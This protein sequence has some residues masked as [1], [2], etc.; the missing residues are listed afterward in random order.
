MMGTIAVTPCMADDGV[1]WLTGFLKVLDIPQCLLKNYKCYP[2][3]C[4]KKGV[5][6]GDRVCHYVPVG[7]VETVN[8]PF[9]TTVP[10]VGTVLSAFKGSTGKAFSSGGMKGTENSNMYF[11]DAHVFDLPTRTFLKLK[12]PFLKLCP[13]GD[14]PWAVYYLSEIDS[15]FGWR[16]GMADYVS[17]QFVFGMLA[18]ITQA[19]T[20]SSA[21]S[22]TGEVIGEK[23]S[24]P[25]LGFLSDVCM[26]T[27]GVTYPRTG[28]SNPTS[29]VVASAIAVY[30]ASRVVAG[31]LT[32]PP[33]SLLRVVLI[34][35][36]FD[37]DLKMQLG[38]P[39]FAKPLN[40]FHKGTSPAMWDN[41]TTRLP[42]GKGYVWVLWEK[43]CCCMPL[44]FCAGLP[45][46][47]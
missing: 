6:V 3:A 40:C 44:S 9:T 24:I 21:A 14:S 10:L 11:W 23:I 4:K 19:C 28:F 22:A 35:K 2:L 29:E 1:D 15:P 34:P 32:I 39:R 42:A 41:F 20:L 8:E 26:G 36:N 25:G 7:F 12:T 17:L 46:T 16:T 30:R 5:P 27:W 13:Y 45:A 33:T 18:Q 43:K 37:P 38:L 47:M 31:K